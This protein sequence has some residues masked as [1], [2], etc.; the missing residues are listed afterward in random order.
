MI[1]IEIF[2]LSTSCLIYFVDLLNLDNWH[3]KMLDPLLTTYGK[4]YLLQ[5]MHAWHDSISDMY[6]NDGHAGI[7]ES[8]SKVQCPTLIFHG[9]QDPM[10][11][12]E[13]AKFLKNNVPNSKYA[14]LSHI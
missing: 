12:I 3:Q 7:M 2:I 13:Q 4:E 8:A 14:I 9:E 10:S 1:V 5:T 11:G 6:R